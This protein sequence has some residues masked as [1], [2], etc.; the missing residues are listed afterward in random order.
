MGRKPAC[1]L[2]ASATLHVPAR[3]KNA[4][5]EEDPAYCFEKKLL[6]YPLYIPQFTYCPSP[7]PRDKVKYHH[8]ATQKKSPCIDPQATARSGQPI[9]SLPIRRLIKLLGLQ[10]RTSFS[11]GHCLTHP[12]PPPA[13]LLDWSCES[14][15]GYFPPIVGQRR[16]GSSA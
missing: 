7:E 6:F 11:L 4:V 15:D 9:I 10:T 16:R 13:A 5:E 8:N 2:R 3:A 12:S 1:A 14:S